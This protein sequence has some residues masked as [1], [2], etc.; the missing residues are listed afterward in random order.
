M[1]NNQNRWN[2]KV[3][4][5]EPRLF[6][7]AGHPPIGRKPGPNGNGPVPNSLTRSLNAQN[8]GHSTEFVFPKLDFKNLLIIGGF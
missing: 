2:S 6:R 4:H 3:H 1:E 5:S 8:D 7:N